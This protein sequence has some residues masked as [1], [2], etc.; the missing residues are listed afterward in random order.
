MDTSD[1]EVRRILNRV[2]SE[3]KLTDVV[4]RAEAIVKK[5]GGACPLLSKEGRCTV[6]DIRPVTCA[7]YHSLD[8]AACHSGAQAYIPF[9]EM[10][11]I[12]TTVISAFGMVPVEMMDGQRSLP[13][14]RLFAELARLG[15]ARLQHGQAA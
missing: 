6:Y 7:A 12:E 11:Y 14:V 8:R 9:H 2:E 15:R 4:S 13:K 1:Y 5:E 10:L 3:N